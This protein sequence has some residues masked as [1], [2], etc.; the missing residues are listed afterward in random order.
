MQTR[1]TSSRLAAKSD[2]DEQTNAQDDLETSTPEPTATSRKSK[3]SP[4]NARTAK[5]APTA[6]DPDNSSA[7]PKGGTRT[8]SQNP[9]TKS[10]TPLDDPKST[11]KPDEVRAPTTEPVA[12]QSKSKAQKFC[13]SNDELKSN[14]RAV[15]MHRQETRRKRPRLELKQI[16]FKMDVSD[17]VVEHLKG[18]HKNTP[19]EKQD[20][21]DRTILDQIALDGLSGTTLG[22][23]FH[24]IGAVSPNCNCQNDDRMQNYVWSVLVGAYMRNSQG[25]G[26]RAFVV[27]R[28]K[29]A[30]LSS[31]SLARSAQKDGNQMNS[32]QG[33][34]SQSSRGPFIDKQIRLPNSTCKR[35]AKY[36]SLLCPVQDGTIMGSCV[37]YLA[38][39]DITQD[40]LEMY[41]DYQEP[42]VSMY[43]VHEKH[44]LRNVYFVADQPVRR[45]AIFPAWA[46]PKVDI[47]LRE[48]CALEMIGKSRTLGTV[49]PNDKAL[50]RYRIMLVA[51]GF[52]TQFQE[53]N[54]SPIEHHL[55][56]FSWK[57]ASTVNILPNQP[58]T[59]KSLNLNKDL[60]DDI[61]SDV[62]ANSDDNEDW[63]LANLCC[64]FTKLSGNRDTLRMVY[65]AI[66]ESPRGMTQVDL[67]KRLSWP[68][69]H[70]R[71]HLKN[72]ISLKLI[73]SYSRKNTQDD[74]DKAARDARSSR[75][76]RAARRSKLARKRAR[77]A[78]FMLPNY[79]RI[80]V[81]RPTTGIMASWDDTDLRA[82]K[83]IGHKRSTFTQAE[84]SLLILCR[85][86]SLLLEPELRSS[87]CVH[88]RVVRDILHREIKESRNKT[89][90]ACLRR[91]KYLRRYPGNI[92]SINEL[93]ADLRYDADIARLLHKRAKA[94]PSDD[95]KPVFVR[96]LK[97][98]RAKLPKLLG[99]STTNATAAAAASAAAAAAAT[100]A[101]DAYELVDCQSLSHKPSS[102]YEKPADASLNAACLVTMACTLCNYF[103]PNAANQ[104]MLDKFFSQ[105]PASFV[106]R[107]FAK[108][109]RRGLLTRKCPQEQAHVFKPKTRQSH[110]LNQNVCMLLAR[111]QS[112]SL[113]QFA[114]PISGDVQLNESNEIGSFAI[115]TSLFSLDKLRQKVAL[116]STGL[117]GGGGGAGG[118][119]DG[120]DDISDWGIA[121][122]CSI[123]FLPSER[124][125]ANFDAYNKF[126]ERHKSKPLTTTTA[127]QGSSDQEARLFKRLDGTVHTTLLFK[128]IESLLS[129][130]I[131][132]PGLMRAQLLAA[133]AQLIP[134]AHLDEL[135]EFMCDLELVERRPLREPLTRPRLFGSGRTQPADER[136]CVYYEPKEGAYVRYSHLLNLAASGSMRA[137]KAV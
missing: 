73:C 100:T 126:I 122:P 121:R 84:D 32:S 107:V 88:K 66:A 132:F 134:E 14:R 109:T 78:E 95:I 46:D 103:T 18:H 102:L 133:F 42:R 30:E 137:V 33:S 36:D 130:L 7:E 67:R 49:F 135:L 9:E 89:S 83:I 98:A 45:R 120:D 53:A 25:T 26:I 116:P 37:D 106:S 15:E 93:T 6:V 112:A 5:N 20:S 81:Q 10:V 60:G 58:P 38:R 47:K 54:T 68:K 114:R 99:L 23:L 71:N 16:D 56:R 110:K 105:Q 11:E 94:K 115:L 2:Q 70:V 13:D 22:R 96:V 86:A 57:A 90:D 62:A 21:I 123:E 43:A 44:N 61:G 3:P 119:G 111:Y 87:W 131:V 91:I 72:L 104:H 113:M 51:K 75:I 85:I 31:G 55:R 52:I 64:D 35:I 82:K 28:D 34:A 50:G 108:L 127:T 125:V 77:R 124:L 63:T 17:P 48:Y 40:V 39:T 92:L 129:W 8:R 1:R 12:T 59:S 128:L 117:R 29:A 69:F 79:E 118:S 19:I 74:D 97:C 27:D 136:N 4:G 24:I 41:D 65:D 80:P 76:Y 101:S